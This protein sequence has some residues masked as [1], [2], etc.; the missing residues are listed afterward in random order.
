[1]VGIASNARHNIVGLLAKTRKG[2]SIMEI[3]L[4]LGA[5]LTDDNQLRKCLQTNADMLRAEGII[6][7]PARQYLDLIKDAANHISSGA[8]APDAFHHI[9]EAIDTPEDAKRLVFSGPSLLSRL[10]DVLDGVQLYP[11][12]AR[13]I[14]ALRKIFTGHQV[15]IFFAIRNPAS[16]IPAFLSSQ[17]AQQK[18]LEASQISAE[19]L[20]WSTVLQQIKRAWPEAKL[21]VWC[22]E[23]TPFLWH[24]LL[25]QISGHTP[26]TEFEGSFDWFDTVMVA[27]AAEKLAQY[28]NDAPPVDEDHRQNV[29]AAFLDK[30]CDD[31][32]LEIDLTTTDWDEAQVDI[33]T[34]IYE[35]DV[36]SL[37]SM[38]GLHLLQPV[39]I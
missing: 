29:I 16:F 18:G 31:Q 15:E 1:M 11:K 13:R 39:E 30:F 27:G 10:P 20:R 35:Q 3:A 14:D 2:T 19:D 17:R 38:P 5:H 9:C 32:K 33:L 24:Q 21:T 23:D 26:E 22:D 28:F 36:E 4:H 34:E 37:S 8:A 6:V 7:P 12:A 25:R